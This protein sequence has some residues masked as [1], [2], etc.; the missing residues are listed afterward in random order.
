MYRYSYVSLP[1]MLACLSPSMPLSRTSPLPGFYFHLQ[2]LYSNVAP[3]E[4]PCSTCC[5]PVILPRSLAHVFAATRFKTLL[6]HALPKI[7]LSSAWLCMC[8]WVCTA[9]IGA[10][11]AV[12]KNS[13]WPC[14]MSC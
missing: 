6:S 1:C 2:S 8:V 7:Q 14:V 11:A 12:N 5:R 9:F 3:G 13:Y 10:G 4:N